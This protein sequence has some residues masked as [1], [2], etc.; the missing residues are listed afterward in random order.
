MEGHKIAMRSLDRWPGTIQQM[1]TISIDGDR[2]RGLDILTA[3][4]R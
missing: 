3:L 1:W 2:G 4:A